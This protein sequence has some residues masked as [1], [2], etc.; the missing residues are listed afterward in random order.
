MP[1]SR[2][3][4]TRISV[5]TLKFIRTSVFTN[6]GRQRKENAAVKGQIDNLYQQLCEGMGTSG[7]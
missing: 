1:F 6:E 3:L 4:L 2:G 5:P 7:G